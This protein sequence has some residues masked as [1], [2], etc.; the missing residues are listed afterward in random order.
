MSRIV[1]SFG[2]QLLLGVLDLFPFEGAPSLLGIKIFVIERAIALRAPMQQFAG[3]Q[4]DIT[5]LIECFRKKREIRLELVELRTRV[6]P[7]SGMLGVTTAKDGGAGGVAGGGGAV[8][9]GEEDA[10]FGEGVD[11]RGLHL[12][13]ALQAPD[14]IVEIVDGD[15]EDVGLGDRMTPGHRDRSK[16]EEKD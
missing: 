10:T 2:G 16:R 13:M 8:G 3:S 7:N 5:G 6:G 9:V 14:P 4:C 15:E 12:G 11:V 1:R